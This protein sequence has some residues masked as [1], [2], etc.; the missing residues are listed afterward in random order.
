[1][2]VFV[3]YFT[4]WQT[5]DTIGHWIEMQDAELALWGTEPRVAYL[6][7]FSMQR[8]QSNI[9]MQKRACSRQLGPLES[10]A[11]ARGEELQC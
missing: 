11:V 4:R 2:V 10:S 5:I 9:L 6:D 7:G 3:F 1:M 8:F